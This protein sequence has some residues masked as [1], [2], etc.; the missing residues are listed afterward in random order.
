MTRR[1]LAVMVCAALV[2]PQASW[3]KKPK[4]GA[5]P[6]VNQPPPEVM[7]AM[8]AHMAEAASLY[9][10][11]QAAELYEMQQTLWSI[12]DDGGALQ[13]QL[14]AANEMQ[15][16]ADAAMMEANSAVNLAFADANI[17]GITAATAQ[18]KAVGGQ[19]QPLLD[20]AA[21]LR[22]AIQAI[23]PTPTSVGLAAV[24]TTSGSKLQRIF[25]AAGW[26]KEGAAVMT[27]TTTGYEYTNFDVARDGKTLNV[28]FIRPHPN[29]PGEGGASPKQ[30]I[31]RAT[32]QTVYAYHGASDTYVEI[33]PREG[34]TEADARALLGQVITP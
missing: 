24:A 27:M 21:A 12:G 1:W 14:D 18:L 7:A 11:I 9:S 17:P 34:A 13:P 19:L 26:A 32:P 6:T 20:A 4:A 25:A 8:E 29:A 10:A 3:A 5:A 23:P 22:T 16:A 15:R 31:A 2:A 28:S 30:V 33:E